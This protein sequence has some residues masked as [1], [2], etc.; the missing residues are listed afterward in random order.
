ANYNGSDSFTY[1]ASDGTLNS[2]AATVI[3]T[4]SPV[5]DPPIAVS[6][7]YSMT[8]NSTL[9]SPVSVLS[10]DTDVDSA[11]LTAILDAPPENGVLS[12][13]ANGSFIYTP[14]LNFFG[15]DTFTYH[16]NDG[17]SN[18]GVTT[19][20]ITVGG[21]NSAPTA[22]NDAFST[23]QDT[24]LNS[25]PNSV[26]NNDHD[27]DGDVLTAVLSTNPVNGALTLNANGTF[28][29]TPN[30]GFFGSDSFTYRANDGTANSNVATVTITVSQ[31]N[32]LPVANPDA[33]ATDE[34]VVLNSAPA[35]VLDNDTDADND[36][37]T[38]ALITNPANGSLALNSNGTFIYTPNLGFFGTDS[39]TYRANDGSGNSAPAAV[40]ITVNRLP[41]IAFASSRNGSS[42]I[43]IMAINGANQMPLT[44]DTR[45]N[46]APTWSPDG[47]QIAFQSSGEIQSMNAD[48]SGRVT[49]TNVGTNYNPV[50]SPNGARIAYLSDQTESLLVWVMDRNGDNQTQL[51]FD[52]NSSSPQWSPDSAQIVFVANCGEV[53]IY[54][55]NADGSGQ[56]IPL[57]VTANDFAPVWS[58]DGSRIAF[59]S[60]RDGNN[61]I[62]V[63]NADGSN[64]QR[65]T[66]APAA[67]YRPAWSHDGSRIAF[68]SE[69]DGVP[70]IYVMNA[71]GSNQARL[72]NNG[73]LSEG[74]LAWSFDNSYIIFTG[75]LAEAPDIFVVN[76]SSGV[77]TALATAGNNFDPVWQPGFGFK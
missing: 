22:T 8:E 31:G 70:E 75:D 53:N 1:R 66:N 48:G 4:I 38:A 74:D 32:A 43:F 47:A 73:S 44:N 35:S 17:H 65:L 33:Y 29:Y 14:N 16:A 39:F 9:N 46:S 7:R 13:N 58:P 36:S 12:F 51:S 40:T 63:M 50:W 28:I 41:R 20:I 64:Q 45:F 68:V 10:N 34:G 57:T 59:V 6:D 21:L 30:A 52:C 55:V 18:S 19:V 42:D 69:R 2:G 54:V 71:N 3:L 56:P 25:A 62:Y 5:D 23:S 72:T 15:S 26:L 49:L 76:V 11:L 61:E 27:P 24:P 37:L 67:D 60:Q 77:Q